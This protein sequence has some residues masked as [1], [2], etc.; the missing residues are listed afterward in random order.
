MKRP[1]MPLLFVCLFLFLASACSTPSDTASAVPVEPPP[2]KKVR[3]NA[4]WTTDY[5]GALRRAKDDGKLVMLDFTGSDWCGWC[6][7]LDSEVFSTQEFKDYAAENLVL[8]KLDFPR[9]I[10]Q[11]EAEKRQ[12]ND[13][14]RRFG[15][16]GFPTIIMLDTQGNPV[17]QMGYQ[18]GGPGPFIDQLKQLQARS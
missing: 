2:V 10:E 1:V 7:R 9:N 15:V 18:P 12:N 17:S 11:S 5:A 4:T 6:K 16:R 13:L 8:V 3:G 14:L